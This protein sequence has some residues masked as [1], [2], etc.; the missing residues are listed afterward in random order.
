MQENDSG[1]S[2][3]PKG[4][5]IYGNVQSDGDL[6]IEGEVDGDVDID[7][8]LELAGAV[9]G[10]KLK[11][12]RVELAEGTIESDIECLDYISIGPGVTIIGDIKAKNADVNGAVKGTI[13]VTENMAVGSTAVISGEVHTKT[14]NVDLGA[15]C[16]IDLKKGYSDE[17]AS[18]FFDEYLGSRA[19]AAE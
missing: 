5:K 11:V 3:I 14:I 15:V 9:R 12:G 19:E 6:F 10:R 4:M 16:D 2:Y 13:D 1:R 7:G 17:R 18:A 8:T